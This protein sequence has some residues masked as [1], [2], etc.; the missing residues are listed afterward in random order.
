[1][2]RVLGLDS[3]RQAASVCR[4]EGL[5][6]VPDDVISLPIVPACLDVVRAKEMIEN[7]PDAMSML[8]EVHRILRPGGQFRCQVPR[9]SPPY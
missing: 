9:Q 6:F 4:F 2:E 1:M 8:R 5:P 7:I 3:E